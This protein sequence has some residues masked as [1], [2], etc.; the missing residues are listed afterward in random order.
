MSCE[1]VQERISLLLDCGCRLSEA[2]GMTWRD[3]EKI[4]AA[5]PIRVWHKPRKGA[6]GTKNGTSRSTY[7]TIRV[8]DIRK[9]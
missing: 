2:L 6:K 4:G 3:I 1:N 5:E 7:Q 9:P 8:A